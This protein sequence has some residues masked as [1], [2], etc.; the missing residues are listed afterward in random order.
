MIQLYLFIIGSCIGSFLLATYQRLL[1][2]KSICIPRSHCD[3]CQKSLSGILL[4]P[5]VSYV[6]TKGRCFY[7]HFKIPTYTLLIEILFAIFYLALYYIFPHYLIY[8]TL[9]FSLLFF[10]STED[11]ATRKV[12][13]TGILAIAGLIFFHRP[14]L[15]GFIFLSLVIVLST[16]V[17]NIQSLFPH[18]GLADLELILCFAMVDSVEKLALTVLIAS[19]SM[20]P[21]HIAFKNH[22]LPFIPALSLCFII[23]CI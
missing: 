6:Y 17:F 15:I 1:L 11:L 14:T 16:E 20:L 23:L 5:I 10:I 9:L 8:H 7:C 19:L 18:I 22:P 21:F 3:T 2:D 4:I 13:S 12:H